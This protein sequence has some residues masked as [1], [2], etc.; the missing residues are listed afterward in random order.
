MSKKF[1]VFFRNNTVTD[2]L[3]QCCGSMATIQ[4]DGRLSRSSVKELAT[5]HAKA[6]GYDG[7][8]LQHGSCIRDMQPLELWVHK[9]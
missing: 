7:F 3:Q 5:N 9:V 1:V 4:V 2:S 8:Q 6:N